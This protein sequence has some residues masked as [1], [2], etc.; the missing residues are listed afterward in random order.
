MAAGRNIKGITVEIGGDTAG[1]QKALS[2]VN[3]KIKSTQA[4]LKDVNNLLKLDPSNTVLVAQKQELLKEAIA[5]TTE[6]LDSLEAAQKDVTAALEAGKIG[7]EQYMAFQREV[8]ETRATLG[9]YE[10]ELAGLNTEQDRLATNTER[11]NKLFDATST[12][13]D[14]YA[15]VLGSKL[16]TAIKNGS[17]S[18]DQLK[19]AIEK[20]GKSAT[21]GKADIK[22]MTDALDTVDDGQAVQNLIQELRDAETQTDDTSEQ[23]D[24]MGQTLTGGVLIEAAEQLSAVGDKITELG[25]K[26]KDA[27]TETQDAT[28]KASTYFGRGSRADRRHHQRCVCGGRGRFYGCGLKRCHNRKKEPAGSGPNRAYA[29]HRAGHHTG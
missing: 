27:F 23:L 20:I 21:D 4:Q 1:L 8:E 11:L 16:L 18:S 10:S 17:A 15:D 5:N 7:Q 28:V 2:D 26:A 3:G 13:V 29:H 14:D 19:M 24:E 9:R 25:E 12:N 6:K 22:Q